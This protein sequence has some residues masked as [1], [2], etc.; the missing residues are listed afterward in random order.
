[1]PFYVIQQLAPHYYG[2]A[3]DNYLES[4]LNRITVEEKNILLLRAIEEYSFEEIAVIM[5]QKAATIRKK[6]ERLRK[7]MKDHKHIREAI[8]DESVKTTT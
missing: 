1:L 2:A 4:L 5:G 6:Y 7:K 3:T 8:S